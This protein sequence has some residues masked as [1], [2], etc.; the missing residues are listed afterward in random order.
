MPEP[1]RWNEWTAELGYPPARSALGLRLALA[2]F[3]LVVCVV[4]V[5]AF[6]A[7]GHPVWLAVFA[8][9]AVLTVVDL[10]MITRRLRSRRRGPR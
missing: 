1:T 5:V 10:V 3:G 4:A 2:I 9:L 6:A 7:S 8:V